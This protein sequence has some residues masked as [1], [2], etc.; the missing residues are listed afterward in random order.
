MSYQTGLSG[1]SAA[2]SDLDVIGNNI[3]NSNTIGFKQGT[4]VF[5]DVYAGSLASAVNQQIGI[6]TTM[7]GV[8]QEFS[9]GTIT[10]TNQALNLAINGLGFYRMDHNGSTQ[11]SRNGV[12]S[13]DKNGYIVNAQG[14]KLTG[15]A[16]NANG[17]IQ[18]ANAV[19]LQMSTSNLAPK[20]T[21][22]VT[23]GFNLN[24][25]DAPKTLPFNPNNSATYN[26]STSLN[27]YD[28][29]G[30]T[31]DFA[32]YYVKTGANTW[33][34]Y[35]TAGNPPASLGKL[36]AM[37][38]DSA[39][40]LTSPTSPLNVSVPTSDG[41]RN[42]I[43]FSLDLS[44]TTQYGSVSGVTSLT[45]NGYATGQLTGFSVGSDGTISGNYSNQQ[46]KTLGQVV[47]ANFNNPNGLLN[48]GGNAFT[49]TDT[50]GLAQVSAPGSTN[51][52]TLTAGAVEESNVDL[53]HSLV[54]LITAQRNYQA[55]AQ[56]VKTQQAVDQT[57]INL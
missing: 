26:Y 21:S 13:L 11:Y 48:I 23:A 27:V 45:Q 35:G 32:M 28:T 42:P 3:S 44:T 51:H 5:A 15:Y 52:G 40:K 46:T 55:N 54:N 47:L 8:N 38:F 18:T 41:S 12:F 17:V 9:Q 22:Q 29:L 33:D 31:K 16:A 19:P 56:T 30:G 25:M 57:L 50:S 36:G 43:K 34:V 7:A 4:A 14:S 37:T 24:S 10:T 39:G 2:S 49:E 20:S 53:T 6:G 1:L